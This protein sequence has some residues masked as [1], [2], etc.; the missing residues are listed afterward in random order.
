MHVPSAQKGCAAMRKRI[1]KRVTARQRPMIIDGCEVTPGPEL[2]SLMKEQKE[3]EEAIG[4]DNLYA[5][6][7]PKGR[8]ALADVEKKAVT[9]GYEPEAVK[10]AV[11]TL[12]ARFGDMPGRTFEDD[13]EGMTWEEFEQRSIEMRE[14]LGL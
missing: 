11:E 9:E 5:A 8:M 4:S 2:L 3:V 7:N 6:L 13:N 1:K 12:R 10:K 14:D